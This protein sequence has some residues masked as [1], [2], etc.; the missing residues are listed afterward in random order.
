M[1]IE[2]T[3]NVP[4]PMPIWLSIPIILICLFSG[5]WIIHWYVMTD[6]ISH[7]G[8]ILGDP[9]AQT[10]WQMPGGRIRGV[11]N[12]NPRRY[13]RDLGN[14]SWELR[15]D[16]ARAEA[17]TNNGKPAFSIITYMAYQFVP[18]DVKNTI[19][20]ARSLAADADRTT[21]LKLTPQQIKQ[22]RQ[23]SATIHM[24]VAPAARDELSN[25]METYVAAKPTERPALEAKVLQALD[26]VAEK[27]MPATKQQAVDRV[28]ADQ[29][30]R[31]ALRCGSRTK[32][33]AALK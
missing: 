20:A 9:V 7:E 27:S 23:L 8:S 14:G 33:W 12:N 32:P 29:R 3:E 28:K 15:N 5:G 4:T 2:S 22:L 31:H 11:G 24:A 1:A 26:D 25:A 10:N 21:A 19:Y 16:Q 6:P 17:T 18:E 30:H 13:V